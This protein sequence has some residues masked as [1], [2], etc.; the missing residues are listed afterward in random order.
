MDHQATFLIALAFTL[1]VSALIVLALWRP[2]YDLL[3]DLCGTERR[4]RFWRC[5]T[6]VMLVLVPVAAVM[7]G[8]SEG[9]AADPTWVAVVDQAKWAVLGL[10]VALFVIA[11]AIATFIQAKSALV[12]VS[13]DQVDD[14][15]RLL[16]KVEEVRARQILRRTEE[17]EERRA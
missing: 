10:I 4:A 5:Y 11:M 13:R 3:V 7:L 15:Q 8:R 6:A 17:T 2:F 14:L 16:A 12:S 1:T 9:R